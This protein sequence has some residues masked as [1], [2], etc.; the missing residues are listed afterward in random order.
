MKDTPQTVSTTEQEKQQ[1]QEIRHSN[2]RQVR[3]WTK[4]VERSKKSKTRL[5]V[6]HSLQFGP[7]Y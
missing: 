6:K 1:V 3:G 7:G 2:K 5:W 4:L